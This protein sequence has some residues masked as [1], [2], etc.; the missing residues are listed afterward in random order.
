[1]V[2][3]INVSNSEEKASKFV[4][5]FFLHNKMNGIMTF[6]GALVKG[7]AIPL[8]IMDT[9]AVIITEVRPFHSKQISDVKEDGT[10]Y[11]HNRPSEFS[12]WKKAVEGRNRFSELLSSEKI[13]LPV[14][15]ITVA[16]CYPF[17][18]Y[19]E[20]TKLGLDKVSVPELTIL[21]DNFDSESKFRAK[22]SEIYRYIYG[23]QNL[24][25][26]ILLVDNLKDMVG[27]A[28]IP[29]FD[30]QKKRYYNEGNSIT[31]PLQATSEKERYYKICSVL[32]QKDILAGNIY[33]ESESLLDGLSTYMKSVKIPCD[34]D[35][36]EGSSI[37]YCLKVGIAPKWDVKTSISITDNCI[38]IKDD[39]GNIL[40]IGDETDISEEGDIL[41]LEGL[42]HLKNEQ[43]R[44]RFLQAFRI[45][46]EEIDIISPWITTG[47]V[48]P[49]FKKYMKESLERGV[50]IKILYGLNS[51]E[52]D[53]REAK[54]NQVVAELEREFVEYKNNGSLVIK[55][56]NIHYKLVLCD[57]E[58]K[59]EGSYN[60]LSF[61]GT[62]TGKDRRREGVHQ[63]RN[64]EEIRYLREEY[65]SNVK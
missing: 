29:D 18:S 13:L 55:R 48:S 63:G 11:F 20:Y 19:E 7:K 24:Q 22:L 41:E 50:K 37:G 33:S 34:C 51:N 61:Q 59:L 25:G 8:I 57:E 54:S 52:G 17:I 6:H 15:Q 30:V 12:P 2:F 14:K 44:K 26:D 32:M 40:D 4:R 43:I 5:E 45:A 1:M 60:F 53:Y 62:Y 3:P 10:I 36:K 49:D 39:I 64:A 46:K 28:L 38:L 16:V 27:C 42:F 58:F 47:V 9:N 35:M 31:I 65:F 23:I 56:D 21:K